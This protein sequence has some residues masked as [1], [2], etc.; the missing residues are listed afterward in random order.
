MSWLEILTLA[1]LPAFLLLDLLFAITSSRP[2]TLRAPLRSTL[3]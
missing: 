2:D 3:R 1:L